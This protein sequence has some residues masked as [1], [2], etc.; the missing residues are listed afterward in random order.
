MTQQVFETSVILAKDN[1]KD[2]EFLRPFS[3]KGVNMRCKKCRKSIPDNSKF[4]NHCGTKQKQEKMYRRP[5]GLYEKSISI[6]GKRKMFRG[7]TEKEVT[8]KILDY[9]REEDLK[10]NG[11]PFEKVAEEWKDSCFDTLAYSTQVSYR[12]KLKRA[13]EH[14]AKTPVTRIE[15]FDIERY[16][17]NFPKSWGYKT[18]V[19]YLSIV[20]MIFDFACRMGYT[21]QNPCSF[22]R[23][24]KGLKREHRRGLTAE[25][26][27]IVKTST[28]TQCGLLAYFILY[29]GLRRGEV[30]A[31]QW[32]DID[33]KNKE[34]TVD[35]SISWHSNDPHI[36]SP[37]TEKGKRKVIL[38]DCLAEKLEPVKGNKNDIVFSDNGKYF[39]NSKLTRLWNKYKEETGLT[40]ITPHM[41]RHS[42]SA[43]LF[44]AG[45]SAKDS[46][47]LLGHAQFSTTMDIYTDISQRHKEATRNTLNAYINKVATQQ[48]TQ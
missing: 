17:K 1:Y 21:N 38:L 34:I 23:V 13:A 28:S 20:S 33:F 2:E 4:C 5:D 15:Y 22:V 36:K 18:Y 42:Y 6:D 14:F 29:T 7:K 40:E 8:Q 43:I 46:Q 16:L 25:E 3:R 41:L 26:I 37:K 44:D 47:D 24:P 9:N 32:K 31:L 27:E 45:I 35:K 48:V 39:L 12:S 11:I 19:G 30:M 10:N